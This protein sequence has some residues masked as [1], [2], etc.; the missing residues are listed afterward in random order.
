MDLWG[1]LSHKRKY[2]YKIRWF[3][4]DTHHDVSTYTYINQ[5]DAIYPRSQQSLY[6]HI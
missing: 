2:A 1:S 3:Y 5:D 4:I 6:T